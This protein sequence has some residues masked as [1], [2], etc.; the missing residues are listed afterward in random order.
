VR[1][2]GGDAVVTGPFDLFPTDLNWFDVLTALVNGVPQGVHAAI[3]DLE[4]PGNYQS[5]MRWKALF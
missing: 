3:A 5:A 4:N 1:L 2:S